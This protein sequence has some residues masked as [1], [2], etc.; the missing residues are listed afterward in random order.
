LLARTSR[1]QGRAYWILPGK[2][3]R[4]RK[5]PMYR[6]LGKEEGSNQTSARV[7]CP[8]EALVV[9]PA[10]K[11]CEPAR[12]ACSP[13]KR[14]PTAKAST[15]TDANEAHIFQKSFRMRSQSPRMGFNVV[16]KCLLVPPSEARVL[17]PKSPQ[18]PSI[19]LGDY[20]SPQD[21]L[22]FQACRDACLQ[23]FP[24]AEDR[25]RCV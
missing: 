23:V 1:T 3:L 16:G 4:R 5:I 25:S 9:K 11:L 2:R 6:G 21:Q 14:L 19:D 24:F 15:K 17:E 12:R 18:P 13:T 7:R 10:R 8:Q 22:C 20:M